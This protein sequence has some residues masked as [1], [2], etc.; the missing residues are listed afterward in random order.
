MR[1]RRVPFTWDF[2]CDQFGIQY[3]DGDGIVHNNT[4]MAHDIAYGKNGKPYEPSDPGI[5]GRMGLPARCMACG[6]AIRKEY[7]PR[8]NGNV[9]D[10]EIVR[11]WYRISPSE[12]M[13]AIRLAHHIKQEKEQND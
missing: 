10:Q 8:E 3:I 2:I 6:R 9:A 11:W 12:R 5:R 1:E 13:D 4:G 7:R